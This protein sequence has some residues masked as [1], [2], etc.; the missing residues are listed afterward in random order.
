M[1]S[2]R[3]VPAGDL[4]VLADLQRKVASGDVLIR[5]VQELLNRPPVHK[6]NGD[7]TKL[8]LPPDKQINIWRRYVAERGYH[9]GQ[10]EKDI[11][12]FPDPPALTEEDVRD[13]YQ[14]VALFYGFR[15]F[16]DS[17]LFGWEEIYTRRP[18]DMS[19]RIVFTDGVM[20][21]RYGAKTRPTGWFW[22]KVNLTPAHRHERR[23]EAVSR[24]RDGE[25]LMGFEWFQLFGI[26]HRYLMD[27]MC[28]FPEN[29]IGAH[30]H[31]R[32]QLA[33]VAHAIQSA[34]PDN[35]EI[36]TIVKEL[37]TIGKELEA[38]RPEFPSLY[39]GDIEFRLLLPRRA[40]DV[41]YEN[42]GG[43]SAI[44]R[45]SASDRDGVILSA[46]GPDFSMAGLSRCWPL[47]RE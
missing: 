14:G 32:R 10:G 22:R 12:K 47:L 18:H 33:R 31:A 21:L 4:R 36:G 40:D 9:T 43:D 19:R 24:L 8:L 7:M 42:V 30:K 26:T 45:V 29:T 13:G 6:W 5:D 28:V 2:E 44:I 34:N 37:E 39:L 41:D 25:S 3:E 11:K 15:S 35:P 17:A 46:L 27:Y 38:A 20:Q 16:A 23:G 1:A